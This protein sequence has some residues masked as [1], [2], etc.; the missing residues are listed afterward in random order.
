MAM[1]RTN[2]S[3]WARLTDGGWATTTFLRHDYET[4]LL[5]TMRSARF[6]NFSGTWRV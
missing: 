1:A 2:V 5:D 6:I 3:F 4:V